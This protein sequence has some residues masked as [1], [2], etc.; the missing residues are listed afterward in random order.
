MHYRIHPIH[1]NE[2][3]CY[4]IRDDETMSYQ[5]EQINYKQEFPVKIFTHTVER[6]PYHWHEDTEILFVLAGELEIRLN[7]N[8]FQLHS[9]DLFLVNGN[10]LHFVNSSNDYKDTQVL[11]LQI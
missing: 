6:F 4:F 3:K 1:F 9:G 8:I 11:V 10:D 2:T 5:Y 7:Q